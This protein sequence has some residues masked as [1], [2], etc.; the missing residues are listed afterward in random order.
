MAVRAEDPR[1]KSKGHSRRS[2]VPCSGAPWRSVRITERWVCQFP[3]GHG[4]RGPLVKGD[5]RRTRSPR[6]IRSTSP[7]TES[8]RRPSPHPEIGE[9]AVR[10][11]VDTLSLEIDQEGRVDR[12]SPCHESPGGASAFWAA[13]NRSKA[14]VSIR[15]RRSRA[16]SNAAAVRGGVGQCA[17]LMTLE[18]DSFWWRRA[19]RSLSYASRSIDIV[20]VAMHFCM[21]AGRPSQVAQQCSLTVRTAGRIPTD[22]HAL[23]GSP[24]RRASANPAGM[25]SAHHPEMGMITT[26]GTTRSVSHQ[27]NR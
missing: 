23:A 2:A 25:N 26:A 22:P 17:R 13:S 8:A 3:A 10:I 4:A 7:S 19:L 14:S 9:R 20:L 16:A 1:R 12:Y 6:R 21:R 27:P 18:K 24:S 5:G 15:G 11:A